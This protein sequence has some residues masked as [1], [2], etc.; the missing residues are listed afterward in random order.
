MKP[1][2]SALYIAA[3]LGLTGLSLFLVPEDG[4]EVMG[5]R[6]HNPLLSFFHEGVKHPSGGVRMPVL[7]AASEARRAPAA[8][9][10]TLADTLLR[11]VPSLEMA[12]STRWLLYALLR[13]LDSLRRRRTSLHILYYGDSQ[14]EGD[15]I[16]AVL[17]DTLQRRFGGGGP[18]FLLPVMTVPYTSTF[19]TDPSPGWT[20]VHNY[21]HPDG[22]LGP[23]PFGIAGSFSLAADTLL[24][25]GQ[26]TVSCRLALHASAPATARQVRR[27]TLA[28]Y[29]GGRPPRLTLLMPSGRELTPA[30]QEQP[31]LQWVE[32]P[33]PAGE[34]RLTL[35]LTFHDPVAVEALFLTDTVGVSVDNIPLRGRPFMLFTHCDSVTLRAMYEHLRV[36]MVV[37]QFGLNV[38]VGSSYDVEHYRH[39]LERELAWLRTTFPRLFVLVVGVTDMGGDDPGLPE[40]LQRLRHIQ[41]EISLATGC[42]YWDAELAMGG[43]GAMR[44]WA[45]H[46]PPWA[47]PDQV[48]FSREGAR[49]FAE[50]LL[51]ALMEDYQEYSHGL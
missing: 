26:R 1:W 45:A 28:L 4:A 36:R 34:R 43:P 32:A 17:R 40:R 30:M 20:A 9:S 35:T 13:D 46:D 42:A 16:T 10:L 21:A 7:S 3:V 22:R 12:D 18:G 48:H 11:S 8:A 33:W 29:P 50:M 19:V 25:A 24:P 38:A 5:I 37:L 49:L 2:K 14:I 47:R 27:L 6:L 51:R 39:T 44:R 23:F 41:R 31:G 15:R